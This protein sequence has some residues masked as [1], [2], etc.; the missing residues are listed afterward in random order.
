MVPKLGARESFM[1]A[2]GALTFCSICLAML[3]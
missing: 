1:V 2:L 3:T